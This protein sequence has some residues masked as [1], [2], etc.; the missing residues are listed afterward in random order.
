MYMLFASPW[1]LSEDRPF[2]MAT[3]AYNRRHGVMAPVTLIH[4]KGPGPGRR[5]AMT[6]NIVHCSSSRHASTTNEPDREGGLEW[7][8][9]SD[10]QYC[11]LLSEFEDRC[12]GYYETIQRYEEV[13]A[14]VRN[15]LSDFQGHGLKSMQVPHWSV[16]IH[17]AC[18]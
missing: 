2:A 15:F 8:H 17:Q 13:V 18:G 9:P 6:R 3:H 14:R 1:P 16:G 7:R 11:S 10:S 12:R 4:L 5:S